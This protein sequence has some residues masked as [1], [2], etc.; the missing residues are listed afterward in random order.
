MARRAAEL[1]RIPTRTPEQVRNYGRAGDELLGAIAVEF[2]CRRREISKRV[3]ALLKEAKRQGCGSGK[4]MWVRSMRITIGLIEAA[5]AVRLARHGLRVVYPTLEK[6]AGVE[7]D[8][9]R[10]LKYGKDRDK[11][12]PDD[13][14]MDI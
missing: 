4:D 12:Q 6:L 2:E 10:D 13:E 3:H 5:V 1:A 11:K 14:R 9:L 8:G 7:I